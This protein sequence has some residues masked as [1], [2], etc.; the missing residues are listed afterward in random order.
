MQPKHEPIDLHNRSK[1][2]SSVSSSGDKAWA[3]CVPTARSPSN[4]QSDFST[5]LHV[6]DDQ[7]LLNPEIALTMANGWSLIV[8]LIIIAVFSAAS[9]F[10]SP[11]GETQTY[12]FSCLCIITQPGETF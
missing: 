3:N 10:L 9:W 11:K 2:L 7:I 4:C 6:S 8:G 12:V 1:Q 5:T